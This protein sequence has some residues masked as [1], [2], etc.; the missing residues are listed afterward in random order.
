MLDFRIEIMGA[1]K[2]FTDLNAW[3]ASHKLVLAVYKLTDAF[4]EKEK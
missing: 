4:S 1:I 3:R 2:S